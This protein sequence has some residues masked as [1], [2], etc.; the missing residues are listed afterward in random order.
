MCIQLF[1]K[2]L[3]IYMHFGYHKSVVRRS[4]RVVEGDTESQMSFGRPATWV[5]GRELVN[6][7]T[8]RE[9]RPTYRGCWRGI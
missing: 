5:V 9:G 6:P 3:E 1:K 4:H 7:A 8:G 2:H